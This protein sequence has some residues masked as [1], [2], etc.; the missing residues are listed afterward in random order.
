MVYSG[1]ELTKWARR[2]HG[3]SHRVLGGPRSAW[4]MSAAGDPTSGRVPLLLPILLSCSSRVA[5]RIKGWWPQSCC[6]GKPTISLCAVLH[7]PVID[8]EGLSKWKRKHRQTKPPSTEPSCHPL[9]NCCVKLLLQWARSAAVI[10]KV[11]LARYYPF[12][13]GFAIV[14]WPTDD[15]PERMVQLIKDT[16][17]QTEKVCTVGLPVWS[18]PAGLGCLNRF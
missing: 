10:C 6:E 7:S 1:Q 18:S 17:T 13:R 9:N 14:S 12:H 15:Q 4:T 2:G 16:R 3:A 11:G 8:F 5:Q